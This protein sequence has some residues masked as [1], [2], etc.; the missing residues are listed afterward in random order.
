[1]RL[2]PPPM[3]SMAMSTVVVL[4][5][6]SGGAA[7]FLM[8]LSIRRHRDRPAG[9]RQASEQVGSSPGR[10]IGQIY[11]RYVRPA[12]AGGSPDGA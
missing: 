3:E 10:S 2:V 9:I 8:A 1:M 11:I 7:L 4:Q 12:D 6:S 5:Q